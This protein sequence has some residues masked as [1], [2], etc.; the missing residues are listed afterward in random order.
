MRSIEEKIRFYTEMTKLSTVAT[1]IKAA[2]EES[3]QA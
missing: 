2:K 1:L 3:K